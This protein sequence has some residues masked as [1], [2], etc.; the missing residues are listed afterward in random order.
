MV[1]ESILVKSMAGVAKL[2][3]SVNIIKMVL[4]A[5]VGSWLASIAD[6]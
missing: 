4:S 5:K 3:M 2:R 1:A 6:Y